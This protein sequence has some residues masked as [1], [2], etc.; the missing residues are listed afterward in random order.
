M[1]EPA[2]APRKIRSVWPPLVLLGAAVGYAIWAQDYGSVP[3]LMPTLV[4]GATAILAVLDLLSRLDNQLGAALRLT[5]GADFRNR[6]MTHDPK[7]SHEAAMIGWMAGCIMAMLIIGIL[8]A[9][10]IFIALY[11]RYWGE[12]PWLQS[13]ISALIVLAFV[14]AVFELLLDYQLYRGVLF[15]PK[16]F[17][18]W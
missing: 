6:E 8:P 14:V 10:P 11:M 5:L 1:A 13:A 7:L 12:Q 15:D 3:R 2:H 4:G 18:A 9:V 17:G 16:G